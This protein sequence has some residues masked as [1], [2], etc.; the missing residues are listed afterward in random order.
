[1]TNSLETALDEKG[2]LDEL[3]VRRN[4]LFERLLKNPADTRLA[5]EIKAI[6]DQVAES[7]KQIER[8]KGRRN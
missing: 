2:K 5:I 3:K 8:K 4:I 6:D 1:M 7:T